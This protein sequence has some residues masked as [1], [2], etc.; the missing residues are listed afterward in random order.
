MHEVT[1]EDNETPTARLN[2]VS[3]KIVIPMV[4]CSDMV[5]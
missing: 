2:G 4:T 1:E 3:A 5:T